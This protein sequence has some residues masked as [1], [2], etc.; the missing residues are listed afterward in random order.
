MS[1]GLPLLVEKKGESNIKGELYKISNKQLEILD[2]LHEI[3]NLHYRK[4]LKVRTNKDDR[5]KL[6]WIY[7]ITQV[8]KYENI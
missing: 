5:P 2:G 4:Q 8:D 3:P 6:C 1:I 7:F